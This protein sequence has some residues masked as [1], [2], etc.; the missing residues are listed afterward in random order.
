MVIIVA[1]IIISIA[2]FEVVNSDGMSSYIK[3]SK[4]PSLY[5][6]YL[7]VNNRQGNNHCL[8]WETYKAHIYICRESMKFLVLKNVLH[9]TTILR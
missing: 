4:A 7:L 6:K 1:I 8:F 3:E 9:I 2:H 5:Y